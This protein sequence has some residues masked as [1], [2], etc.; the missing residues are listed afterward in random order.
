MITPAAEL[1]DGTNVP[2]L[3]SQRERRVAVSMAPSYQEGLAGDS[4][5][6]LSIEGPQK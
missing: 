5:S 4:V 2:A 6:G 1:T 3:A